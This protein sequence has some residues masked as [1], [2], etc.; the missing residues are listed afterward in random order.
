MTP[1][2][3]CVGAA[4]PMPL[5]REDLAH[6]RRVDGFDDGSSARF[7]GV[8]G[9]QE[10]SVNR[11]EVNLTTIRRRLELEHARLSALLDGVSV[12]DPDGVSNDPDTDPVDLASTFLHRG[13]EASI[14]QRL[15]NQLT[16]V[17]A[18]LQRLD[19]GTYGIDEVT[20][21]PIAP[22]RLEAVP[23]ARRNVSG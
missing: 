12:G 8:A 23:T 7:A 17:E 3:T 18:A 13:T 21:A 9:A 4:F 10:P 11:T 19:D 20:G 1:T 15:R 5:D 16:E 14:R 6:H 2:G 22:E